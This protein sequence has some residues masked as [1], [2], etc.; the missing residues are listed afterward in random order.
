MS[1]S[2]FAR[3]FRVAI[4][5]WIAWLAGGALSAC[6]PH[7][8]NLARD[9]AELAPGSFGP[10]AGSAGSSGTRHMRTRAAGNDEGGT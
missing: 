2:N 10:A 1:A 4:L 5:V 3:S 7:P 8:T 9:S 6:T